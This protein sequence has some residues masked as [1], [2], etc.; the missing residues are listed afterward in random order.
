MK[1]ILISPKILH[2]KY[3]QLGQFLDL[4][5]ASFFHKK[6]EIFTWTPGK[7][8]YKDF[9]FD[10][11]VLS[12]GNDLY[13]IKKNKENLIRDRFESRLVELA[14]K[15]SIPILSVCRGFQFVNKFFGGSLTKVK[16]HTKKNHNIIFKKNFSLFKKNKILN[17]NSYHNYKIKNLANNFLNIAETKDETIEI[18]YA[19]KEKILG[20]MFH[21]ERRNLSEIPVNK[22][23]FDYFN[24]K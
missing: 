24:I 2:D 8:T 14:M 12:G 16:N 21:P 3:G 10:G 20:L 7:K 15:K 6:A 1:K 4:S 5:W 11:L 22:L 13:S 23:I 17:V 18:A 19:K 9:N